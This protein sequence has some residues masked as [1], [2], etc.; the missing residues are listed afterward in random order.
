[1]KRLDRGIAGRLPVAS[2]IALLVIATATAACVPVPQ[3]RYDAPAVSGVI[4]DNGV[5]VA[6][7][8]VRIASQFA[9]DVR[10]ATTAADGRFAAEPIRRL[11]LTRALFGDPVTAYAVDIAVGTRRYDG[12][13]D[14]RVGPGPRVLHLACDLSRP[15]PGGAARA[16]C[17][18]VP[19]GR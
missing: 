5:P 15:A 3:Y 2:R 4:V 19:A 1:M 11:V 16:H 7:A 18:P 6:G 17:Q 10:R 13:A 9:E 14:S 12:Y 8:E